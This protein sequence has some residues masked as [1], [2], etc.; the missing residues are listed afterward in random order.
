MIQRDAPGL[1]Q[2][3]LAAP[4]LEQGMA[5]PLLQLADLYGQGRLRQVQPLRRAGQVAIMGHGPEI[6][7][8]MKVQVRHSSIL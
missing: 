3:Q 2:M 7:Q 8:V 4:P 6:A 1:G 5:Q